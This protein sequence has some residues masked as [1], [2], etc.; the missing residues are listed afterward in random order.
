MR[1]LMISLRALLAIVFLA[2]VMFAGSSAQEQAEPPKIEKRQLI[3][4]PKSDRDK[5]ASVFKDPMAWVQEKQRAF[6]SSMNASLRKMKTE[7]FGSAAWMLSLLG[8]GYGVF[9]A[10]GP[11][12]G[13][14]VISGWLLATRNELK[15]GIFISLVSSI[16]Q[17]LSAIV[18]VSTVLFVI[19]G[20]VS[21]TRIAAGVLESASYALIGTLGMYL[22]WSVIRPA[23]P[24]GDT[25]SGTNHAPAASHSNAHHDHKHLHHA[26]EHVH[27]PGCGHSHLPEA[28]ELRNDWS[29]TKACS[30]AFAIG[31]RPCTG[32]I[33]V[34]LAAYPM[35]LYWAGILSV[36]AMAAGTFLTVSIIASVT[37]YSRHLA[38]RIVGDGT[39]A[40][41]EK[42]LRLT[43][44]L[45][46]T[47]LGGMLFWASLGTGFSVG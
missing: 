37:V 7:P 16:V 42:P 17:A 14:A 30:M 36:F 13:K 19:S 31:L 23:K 45:V 3:V 6:Y 8:F 22:I 25:I 2:S 5:T 33:L 12:H 26:S 24:V 43:A 34:L 47:T 46:V 21:T 18:I 20:A 15:R 39:W 44:G 27:G 40:W 9:H 29:L 11:G 38:M 10:A 1:E 28:R 32:A 41:I 35:G 4:P